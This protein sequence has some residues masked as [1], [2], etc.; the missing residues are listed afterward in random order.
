MPATSE[1]AV[2]GGERTVTLG[3][4]A[5]PYFSDA[6][7]EFVRQSMIDSRGDWTLACTAA[8]GG[9]ATKLEEHFAQTIGRRHAIATAGGGPAL[10]IACLAAGVQLGDEVITTPYSW[11]QTVSCILQAGGIPI[12]G[13]IDPRTLTLDPAAIE[14]LVTDRTRAIVLVH[15]FGIPADMDAIMAIARRRNLKVIEDCAQAQ[16]SLYKGRQVGSFG[17]FGCFSIGSGKNLA[18][19]DG[20]MLVVDDDEL[21]EQALLAGMHPARLFPQIKSEANK[22]RISSLIYTYRINAF[23][24]ALAYKQFER[25]D[26]N[27][28]WRRR[29]AAYLR[30]AL[31]D[32]PG[33][34]AIDLPADRD[35]AWHILP[36][37]FA[38]DDFEGKVTRAQY[39]KALQ[40]EGVPIGGPYV[41]RPIHTLPVFRDKQWWLGD[42]Y[43]WKANPRG[44]QIT[45]KPGDCPVAER[46]SAELDMTMGGGSWWQ[47][48]TPLLDQIAEAFR[49]VTADPARLA[50]IPVN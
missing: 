10:H 16:G 18:A 5:W 31:A 32:I 44:D 47:D 49:K 39:L 41:S 40:A 38:P 4:P 11:G 3:S 23:T 17:D 46:R 42:G 24:A 28:A 21:F 34:R 8:V 30:K 27:N 48:V 20:G 43:P 37:T 22:A 7:I 14:P 25:L 29:N 1:L 9:W 19:G 33:I 15:P 2:F 6:E 36:W 13:D 45:Y 26:E 35:P 12:F 50:E